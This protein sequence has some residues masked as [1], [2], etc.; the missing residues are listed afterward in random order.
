MEV[1]FKILR[2]GIQTQDFARTS[3]N[4]GLEI[5]ELFFWDGLAPALIHL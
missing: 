2:R 5:F 4:L 3:P 1:K